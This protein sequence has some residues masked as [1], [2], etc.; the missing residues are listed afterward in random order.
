MCSPWQ[1]M[2]PQDGWMGAVALVGVGV[3]GPDGERAAG[4]PLVL[5]ECLVDLVWPVRR[6][7]RPR[8]ADGAAGVDA[9]G[10]RVRCAVFQRRFP[11][12]SRRGGRGQVSRP[13]VMSPAAASTQSRSAFS[14]ARAY[15]ASKTNRRGTFW[16]SAS[17]RRR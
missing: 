2:S 4:G 9:E 16:A 15:S 6:P 8:V 7:G 3:V 14:S 12:L 17:S 13:L 10:Q 1:S 11:S 5:G